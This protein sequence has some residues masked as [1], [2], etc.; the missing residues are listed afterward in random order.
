M[1]HGDLSL[2]SFSY[3]NPEGEGHHR[4][5]VRSQSVLVAIDINGDGRRQ[6]WA[7]ELANRENACR[8]KDFL[9]ALKAHGMNGVEF[10]VSDDHAG[11]KRHGRSAS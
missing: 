4:R 2:I 3:A 6:V 5:I 8:W 9:V 1:I 10:G 7:G 11:L